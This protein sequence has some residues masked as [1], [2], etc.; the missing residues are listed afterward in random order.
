M[1]FFKQYSFFGILHFHGSVIWGSTYWAGVC[2]KSPEIGKSRLSLPGK[3]LG[4]SPSEIH[5]FCCAGTDFP[6]IG[7]GAG[8]AR[9]VGEPRKKAEIVPGMLQIQTCKKSSKKN[10][11]PNNQI[12]KKWFKH[13]R[14]KHLP[15]FWDKY[16]SI[17]NFK[18]NMSWHQI[19]PLWQKV[20]LYWL[21]TLG[22]L[23][24]FGVSHAQTLA[25]RRLN[26]STRVKTGTSLSKDVN[27][28]M[29]KR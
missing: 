16:F 13:F 29:Q 12:E 27:Q 21:S 17:Q 23:A 8:F 4:L 2:Q 28:K 15:N 3:F 6:G 26:T 18:S 25:K 11:K 1:F 24:S 19:E 20:L 5:P 22:V 14:L 9:K 10:K 7:F